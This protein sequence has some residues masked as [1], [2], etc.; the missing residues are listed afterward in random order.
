[1]SCTYNT[2]STGS[3]QL[4]SH[5]SKDFSHLILVG[6]MARDVGWDKG[7]GCRAGA[8]ARM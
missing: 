5:M 8:R 1:M 2:N 3:V 4:L 7:Q 6:A